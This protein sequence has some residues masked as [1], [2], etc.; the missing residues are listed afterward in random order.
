[1]IISQIN[2]HKEG[3]RVG[4]A[5][6]NGLVWGEYYLVGKKADAIYNAL[7]KV[8]DENDPVIGDKFTAVKPKKKRKRKK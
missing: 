5:A 3:V 4:I 8:M 1:M 7:F 6:E 2:F